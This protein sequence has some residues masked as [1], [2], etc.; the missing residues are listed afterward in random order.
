MSFIKDG[1]LS[2]E[3]I[4]MELHED[5]YIVLRH[6]RDKNHSLEG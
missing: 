5:D 6:L 3:A 1:V 4:K 2:R